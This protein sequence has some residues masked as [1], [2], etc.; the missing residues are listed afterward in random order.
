MESGFE[1]K[2]RAILGNDAGDDK[3][4]ILLGRLLRWT[5]M[6][7]AY[8][9]DPKHRRVILEEFGMDSNTTRPLTVNGDKDSKPD[10]EYEM[11]E[12]CKEEDAK[13]LGMAARINFMSLDCPDLQFPSKQPAREMSKPKL[14]SWK[15]LKNHSV[16]FVT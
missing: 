16:S 4:V 9:A 7:I 3:E 8:E 15:R 6:G 13:F 14:G 12:L 11:E 10:E 5:K 2:V 1:I